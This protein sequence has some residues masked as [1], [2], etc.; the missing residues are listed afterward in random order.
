M[1]Q[2]VRGADAQK[3]LNSYMG[4]TTQLQAE[5]IRL[6]ASNE[7]LEEE[8]TRLQKELDKLKPTT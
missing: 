6:M 1:V 4:L 7:S 2:P 5:V 3:I 8:N